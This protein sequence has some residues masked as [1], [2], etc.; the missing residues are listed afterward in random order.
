MAWLKRIFYIKSI[1]NKFI[2]A[3]V[4]FIT[5]PMLI[6]GFLM[7]TKARSV[8]VNKINNYTQSTLSFI[9]TDIDNLIKDCE[10]KFVDLYSR[11]TI[12]SELEKQ[13]QSVP[14]D[15]LRTEVMIND[16][17]SKYLASNI[18]FES[19]YL[20]ANN[21]EVY[22]VNR[23]G[24]I[25]SSF[26]EAFNNDLTLKKEILSLKGEGKI[27]PFYVD[28]TTYLCIARVLKN[29]YSDFSNIGIAVVTIDLKNIANVCSDIHVP[30]NVTLYI[31]D[32]NN[33]VVFK[34]G[35]F[36]VT[37]NYIT[38]NGSLNNI[39]SGKSGI[40]IINITNTP[41]ALIYNTAEYTK[42][43]CIEFVQESQLTS[44]VFEIKTY[45][46]FVTILSIFFL[47][48]III[49]ASLYIT[50][51]IKRLAQAMDK[52]KKGNLEVNVSSKSQD[53]VGTLYESFNEMRLRIKTLIED[54][55][56]VSKKEKEAEMQALK[57]QFNPHFL[58]NALGAVNWIAVR[59][60]QFEI[61]DM[62]TSLSDLLRYS[63]D[64]DNKEI[65]PLRDDIRWLKSYSD[66]Q[67]MRFDKKFEVIFNIDPFV[68]ECRVHKLLIQPLLENSI[69]HG[70]DGIERD[71]L[72]VIN[73]TGEMD[74]VHFEIVDNGKGMDKDTL[75]NI[76][77]SGNKGLGI[78]NVH[79]R[80]KLYYGESY[81]LEVESELGQGLKISFNIPH[82][83]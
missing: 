56:K 65:V 19:V 48:I 72:I 53:E 25:S 21:N 32:S 13:N 41:Y 39:R 17:L 33:K 35:N 15:R 79:E 18:L 60:N 51:P 73:I 69:I 46:I 62:L 78:K 30:K 7:Y 12:F 31:L 61:S 66:F 42:W 44:E 47:S 75:A 24:D 68:M 20:F 8:L 10:L 26:R 83:E 1:S 3:F 80:I 45:F 59:N 82:I 2:F 81:G 36:E 23:T 6:N 57:S 40:N 38:I 55:Q 11:K 29:I 28:G 27:F 54:I 77:S 22:S 67:K 63:L 4:I 34:K 76:T 71:G 74:K 5:L 52:M 37:D 43:T 14:T 58:Y 16:E 50:N 49:I 64:K 70:L 9:N